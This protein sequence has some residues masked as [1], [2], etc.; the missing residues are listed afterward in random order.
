METNN[1][2]VII[3]TDCGVDDA[4]G[5]MLALHYHNRGLIHILGIT[6]VYGNVSVDKVVRNVLLTLRVCGAQ[7]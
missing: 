2:Y 7:V 4:L 5:L 6:C 1:K 3:D